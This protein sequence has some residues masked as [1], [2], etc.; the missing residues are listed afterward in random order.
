MEVQLVGPRFER[1]VVLEIALA[2]GAIDLR[3]LSAPDVPGGGTQGRAIGE[4]A[5]GRPGPTGVIDVVV[6]GTGQNANA[7]FDGQPDGR[8]R[9]QRSPNVARRARPGFGAWQDK[10]QRRQKCEERQE[11]GQ[12]LP[13][14]RGQAPGGGRRKPRVSL[15]LELRHVLADRDRDL[16]AVG[17]AGAGVILSQTLAEA[18][19]LDADNGVGL[20]IEGVVAAEGVDGN[21]VFLDFG[22]VALHGLLTEIGEQGRQ[23]GGALEEPGLEDGPQ[24][25]L[26]GIGR[27]R[28]CAGHVLIVTDFPTKRPATGCDMDGRA[29]G[30]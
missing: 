6:A 14:E 10:G 13:G 9:R 23:R 3:V 1:D 17:R 25:G 7:F 2:A 11:D 8:Q 4:E 28:I 12:S 29:A 24:L 20:L 5:V 26:L 18:V 27:Y 15:L 30:G 16:N 21:A 22:A 19:G